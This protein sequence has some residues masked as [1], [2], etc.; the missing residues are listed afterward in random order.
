MTITSALILLALTF[1]IVFFIVMQ[2]RITTQGEVNED[3]VEGTPVSAPAGEHV[4]SYAIWALLISLP[5]WGFEIW[6]IFSGYLT[7]EMFDFYNVVSD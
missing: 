5:I 3:V 4:R 7:I 2:T 1:V 6:L